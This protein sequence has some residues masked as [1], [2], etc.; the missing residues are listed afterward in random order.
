[1]AGAGGMGAGGQTPVGADPVP[2]VSGSSYSIEVGELTFTADGPSGRVTGLMFGGG[3][4]LTTSAVNDTNYGSS[5]WTSP[6]D[7]DWPPGIDAADYTHSVDGESIVFVSDEVELP[8]NTVSVT[9]SFRGNASEGS[10][11]LEYIV[12][13]LGSGSLTFAPWEITRV[14]NDGIT[15]YPRGMNDPHAQTGEYSPDAI[16]TV[17]LGDDMVWYDFSGNDGESKSVSDGAEGWLAHVSDGVLLLKVW[18]DVAVADQFDTEGEVEIYSGPDDGYIE[19]EQQGARQTVASGE[20]SAPW[21]VRWYV[22]TL[23]TDVDESVGSESLANWVR[24]FV[25]APQP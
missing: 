17:T 25:A 9:K 24:A 23:P 15:F 7:W 8:A 22:R 3:N 14:F 4:V 20:Q 19:L 16:P 18:D 13:N 11:E 6:Q 12:T 2:T 5:F 1:M 10:I 21:N